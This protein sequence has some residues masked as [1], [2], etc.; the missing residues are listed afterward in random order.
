[1]TTA[2]RSIAFAL[3][4]F[5]A[6]FGR[7]QAAERPNI[8]MIVSDDHSAPYVNCYGVQPMRTPNLDR[9]AASGLRADRFFVGAPQCVP[10]R[11]CFMT[12]RSAVAAKITRFTSPLAPD[13]KTFAEVL[14]ESGYFTGVCRRLFH[15][16]GR[17]KVGPITRK[18]YEEHDLETFRRRL[19]FVDAGSPPT[20]TVAKV[21]EFFDACPTEKPYFLWVNFN[22]PHHVWDKNAMSPPFD[23]ADVKL[24]AFVPDTTEMRSDYALYLGEIERMDAEFQSVLDAVSKRRGLENTLIVFFGD[25]GMALPRGKGSLYDRGLNVPLLVGWQGRMPGNRTSAELLSGEDIGPTLLEAAGC[26]IPKEMTGRSFLNLLVDRP[27]EPRKYVFAERGPHGGDGILTTDTKASTF[28][29]SRCVRSDQYKLIYNCT[30]YQRYSPVDSAGDP[31]WKAL[32]TAHDAGKLDPLFERLYFTWPRPVFE[33]YD[34]KAD[35]YELNNLAGDKSLASVE[36]ELKAALTEKMILDYDF[37][38]LPLAE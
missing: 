38:P 30:P 16:D 28:D 20:K 37:L 25:N 13:V 15:L 35:P 9:F 33:L 24:P 14:R 6:M 22:D 2:R 32:L 18:I 21:N 34:L 36:R 7:L 29:L 5:T 26:T 8:L 19:D 12:G 23:P 10:S 4:L 1:M 31:G 3:I 27:H 17:A 11:G